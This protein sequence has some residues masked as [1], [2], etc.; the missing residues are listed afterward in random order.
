M[1]GWQKLLGLSGQVAKRGSA[2]AAKTSK[3]LVEEMAEEGP[4]VLGKGT[5]RA[6]KEAGEIPEAIYKEI[7]PTTGMDDM[8]WMNRMDPRLKK[9]IAGA[10]GIGAGVTAYNMMGGDE[11]PTP[12]APQDKS[13]L[14]DNYNQLAQDEAN[15]MSEVSKKE[16]KKTVET[17]APSI[18]GLA[19]DAAAK[20][21]DIDDEYE[22]ARDR[23]D[24]NAL[25]ALLGKASTQIGGG[26]ASLGAGSQVSGDASGFEDLL[27]MSDRPLSQL[28]EKQNY[29]KAKAEL[30]DENAMR[31][32]NS[33]ISRMVTGIAQKVGIL[34]AGQTASAMDL[35]NAGVNLGTLLSTIEAGKARTEAAALAREA[36]IAGKEEKLSDT[37]RK[38][39]QGLRKE[40]TTGVL[41]KQYSTFSTGQR[42]SDAL[43]DFAKDPS[44]YSD[45]ATLMGGLKVL[46][47]DESV[48]R[49]AEVRMGMQATSLFDGLQNDLQKLKSGKSLQPN[50]R[51]AMIDTIKTLTDLS[52][53]Q[54][55]NSVKP[56]LEQA[57]MEGID[58]NLILSGSLRGSKAVN[59]QTNNSN[60][61]VKVLP[62][63]STK[64][65][66]IP[67]NE[68]DA[69]LAAGGKLVE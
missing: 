17:Q 66:L 26:I 13:I 68:V 6:A 46:Q 58:P 25:V 34:K 51:Q 19:I 33:E 28:K 64:P 12:L 32:P 67:A 61:M 20:K 18:D 69:A 48:V 16:A 54:Y 49:E 7:T 63:G 27:K 62:P 3:E 45:Y 10:G 53:Q 31:D 29:T 55:M 59:T 37:Q 36:R 50:Q 11:P 52:K 15:S 30:N 41:G 4:E 42:M 43:S 44:G 1:A 5:S 22:I 39:A 14:P 60:G 24:R 35:K 57:E 40:A 65:K 38:F 21:T 23:S 9:F 8:S 56:I 47:G 2:K